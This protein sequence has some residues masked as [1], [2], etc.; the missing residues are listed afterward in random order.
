MGLNQS[1]QTTVVTAVWSK[2]IK[3]WDLMS[4][5][6]ENLLSLTTPVRP[7]YILECGDTPPPEF[8]DHC[9]TFDQRLSIYQA[10]DYGTRIATTELAMNLNLDDRLRRNALEFLQRPFEV[11]ST[12]CVGGE[13]AIQFDVSQT[14]ETRFVESPSLYKYQSDWPPKFVGSPLRLGSSGER[15]TLGPATVWRRALFDIIRFPTRFGNGDLIESIG[16][17]CF[18]RLCY[19][20]NPKSII[21]VPLIIG[22]YY[23]DPETQAEFRH[24]DESNKLKRFG[25]VKKLVKKA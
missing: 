10:W 16:D 11:P 19:Q 2:D 6:L 14:E 1:P 9:V 21:R 7:L 24:G 8:T 13:W 22:D 4:Q 25:Y 15:G 20:I 23:S 5:H 17:A 3:R 18:W 12:L